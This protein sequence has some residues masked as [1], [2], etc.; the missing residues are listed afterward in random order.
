VVSIPGIRKRPWY[1]RSKWPAIVA[2]IASGSAGV[3]A[4][5]A[6]A[7]A[8]HPRPAVLIALFVALISGMFLGSIQVAKSDYDDQQ[9]QDRESPDEIRGPLHAIHRILATYK[10][11]PEP[12]AE[13]LRLT[14][15][16]VNGDALEQ[17]VDYVGSAHGGAGRLFSIHAGLIGATARG[18]QPRL[19][20]R[21]AG[22]THE[23]WL[24]YLVEH[25]GMTREQARAT[26]PGRHSFCG[27]PIKAENGTVLAVLYMDAASPGFF[28][29]GAMAIAIAGCKGLAA[30]IHERYPS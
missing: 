10:R 26:R 6:E 2:M 30:W 3:G 16:R 5:F 17:I 28:D 25:M 12:G 29:P 20:D 21:P 4:M 7:W 11:F 19:F 1:A 23:E 15:H 9:A 24:S 13:C 27:I 22:T 8:D 14:L 18:G